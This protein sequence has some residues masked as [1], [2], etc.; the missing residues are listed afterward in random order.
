MLILQLYACLMSL[1]LDNTKFYKLVAFDNYC[2]SIPNE[3]RLH[4]GHDLTL[5]I[6]LKDDLFCPLML[7]YN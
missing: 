6:A 3:Y 1:C 4:G 2:H 7:Q 5:V